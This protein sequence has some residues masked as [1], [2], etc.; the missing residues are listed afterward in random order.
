MLNPQNYIENIDD[1]LPDREVHCYIAVP[2]TAVLPHF[3]K[4]NVARAEWLGYLAYRIGFTPIMPTRMYHGMEE[5]GIPEA[6]FYEL[7]EQLLRRCNAVIF[8]RGWEESKGC[9]NEFRIATE[10]G[11]HIA[12]EREQ[13]IVSGT[14]ENQNTGEQ[15][16]EGISEDQGAGVEYPQDEG[17][18]PA[19]S[20]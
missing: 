3:R 18:N 15:T 11:L 20:N 5:W 17:D 16:E 6:D 2:Y 19:D 13:Y 12:R 8:S 7:S 4:V 9:L 10:L 14:E 1:L